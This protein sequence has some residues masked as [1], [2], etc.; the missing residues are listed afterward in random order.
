LPLTEVSGTGL[1]PLVRSIVNS[2]KRGSIVNS[3]KRGSIVNS[4]KQ[5][6]GSLAAARGVGNRADSTGPVALYYVY[7][8]VLCV[9]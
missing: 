5:G 2:L 9:L 1:T 6:L 4:L 8:Y 7:I 3:L